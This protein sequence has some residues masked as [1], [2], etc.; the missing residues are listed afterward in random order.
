MDVDENGL[1]KQ[2]N[3]YDANGKLDNYATYQP[4]GKTYKTWVD[5]D[6]NGTV[7]QTNNYDVNGNLI[8][9]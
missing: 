4:D 9:N 7:V 8:S 5:V 6:E 1:T 2:V 3:N